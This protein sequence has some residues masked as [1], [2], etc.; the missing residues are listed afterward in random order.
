MTKLR[1]ATVRA[2]Y[3]LWRVTCCHCTETGNKKVR[4][5]ER[6]STTW[7]VRS[8][9]HVEMVYWTSMSSTS[10]PSSSSW[11]SHLLSSSS[12]VASVTSPLSV[13]SFP[14]LRV[15]VFHLEWSEPRIII[16]SIYNPPL[17]FHS[18]LPAMTT[19]LHLALLLSS[20]TFCISIP[21]Q[22]ISK[23]VDQ[24]KNRLYNPLV[25]Y[26][27][28]KGEPQCTWC[29]RCR[30]C[31]A[32]LRCWLWREEGPRA[33][34]ARCEVLSEDHRALQWVLRDSE[35]P[36]VLEL[37]VAAGGE[38]T[39]IVMKGCDTV[40]LLPHYAGLECKVRGQG[41]ITK[42][43]CPDHWSVRVADRMRTHRLIT[44]KNRSTYVLFDIRRNLK[45]VWF[46]FMKN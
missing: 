5:W 28:T 40:E 12:F 24:P 38:V 44:L 30:F 36:K 9:Q 8:Y 21:F 32:T 20:L 39:K 1:N 41:F 2:Y 19:L 16:K 10:Y 31:R 15:I 46:S 23:H 3:I 18:L 29:L 43:T 17:L 6:V 4:S 7:P 33:V 45:V 42:I 25:C 34:W 13:V 14:S 35:S 26:V 22:N 37:A 11:A 27:E